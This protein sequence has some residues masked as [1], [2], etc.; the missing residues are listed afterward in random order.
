MMDVEFDE[1]QDPTITRE[2]KKEPSY[3]VQLLMKTKVIKTEFQA[4]L[5]MV[6]IAVVMFAL[7]LYLF[8]SGEDQRQDNFRRDLQEQAAPTPSQTR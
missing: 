3:L 5:V 7:S 8:A 6:V 4:N 2:V 1:P